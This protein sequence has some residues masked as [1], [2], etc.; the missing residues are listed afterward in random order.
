MAEPPGVWSGDLPVLVGPLNC[1]GG[2]GGA[3]ES[4]GGAQLPHLS[5][6]GLVLL[7]PEYKDWVTVGKY[8]LEKRGRNQQ[9]SSVSMI[10]NGSVACPETA[11]DLPGEA[12]GPRCLGLLCARRGPR[13]CRFPGRCLAADIRGGTWGPERPN[14]LSGSLQAVRGQK[15]GAFPPEP[16]SLL[17][18]CEKGGDRALGTL[19]K[20]LFVIKEEAPQRSREHRSA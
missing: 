16:K 15:P 8:V 4:T 5:G 9:R 18:S 10:G 13:L 6:W 1:R 2:G 7:A 14:G 12:G 3:G 11:C 20:H 17:S 19:K